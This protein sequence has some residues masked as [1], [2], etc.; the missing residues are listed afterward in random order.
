VCSLDQH[1]YVVGGYDGV[2]QLPSA[3]RY[4]PDTDQW[5]MISPLNWPRS[6]LSLAVVSN[7]I[8]TLGKVYA[9]YSSVTS[10]NSFMVLILI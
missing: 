1:V 9:T 7:K 4:D 5:Q 2:N 6:A 10:D 8:Y 3:E